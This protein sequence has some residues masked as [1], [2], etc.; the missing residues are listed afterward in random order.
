MSSKLG[1]FIV[2]A[3]VAVA[4]SMVVVFVRIMPSADIL[5]ATIEP[6]GGGEAVRTDTFAGKPTVLV[7]F[8]P[9]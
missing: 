4:V 7:L 1:W 6:V 9:T 3:L 8:T 2:L 5:G